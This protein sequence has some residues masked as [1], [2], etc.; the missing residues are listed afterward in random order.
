MRWLVHEA[1]AHVPEIR[2]VLDNLNTNRPASSYE[3]FPATEAKPIARM[4][5]IHY[6]PRHGSWL[7]MAEI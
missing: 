2:L 6:A 3:T 5:E 1:Y 4:V 7:N